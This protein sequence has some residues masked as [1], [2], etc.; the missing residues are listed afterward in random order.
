V[1]KFLSFLLLAAFF[2]AADACCVEPPVPPDPNPPAPLYVFQK[3]ASDWS[4]P[5]TTATY[6]QT[7]YSRLVFSV[8][9]DG[10]V[11]ELLVKT[12]QPGQ[13]TTA[14]ISDVNNPSDKR[15][16]LFGATLP[17]GNGGMGS[18]IVNPGMKLVRG[19]DYELVVGIEANDQYYQYAMGSLTFPKD[20]KSKNSLGQNLN[21]VRFKSA[22]WSYHNTDYVPSS[23]IYGHVDIKFVPN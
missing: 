11:T 16:V 10:Y 22:A 15:W 18:Y 7:F 6:P 9:K 14:S 3:L 4:L 12:P 20:V 13:M 5:Q 21:V 19:K 2:R 8:Y 1:K 23:I 17:S